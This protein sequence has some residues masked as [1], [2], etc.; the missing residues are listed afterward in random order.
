MEANGTLMEALFEAQERTI[1]EMET[2]TRQLE[3]EQKMT[4]QQAH[5]TG[6]IH[7]PPA[8]RE[9]SAG[10]YRIRAEDRLGE[11]SLKQKCRDN[12]AAIELVNRLDTEGRAATD[13]D[14]HILVKH[15]G[16]G[17]IPQVFA[18]HPGSDWE[19]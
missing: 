15:V 18:Q 3:T 2:L 4:P 9:L 6:A 5:D 13:A 12:F 11:G 17:G 19:S 14:K 1:E 16:W 10:N 8:G 7:S